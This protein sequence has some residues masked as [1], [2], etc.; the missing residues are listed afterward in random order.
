MTGLVPL[1]NR[2]VSVWMAREYRTIGHCSLC[3][4]IRTICAP[5]LQHLYTLKIH[6]F[7]LLLRDSAKPWGF[8]R[9]NNNH[10]KNSNVILDFVHCPLLFK[11]DVSESGFV[12]FMVCKVSSTVASLR[13]NGDHAMAHDISRRTLVAEARNYSQ[14]FHVEFKADKLAMTLGLLRSVFPYSFNI[15]SPMIHIHSLSYHR[16]CTISQCFST[17]ARPRPGKFF[18]Y[19]TRPQSQQIYS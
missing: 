4:Q 10:Q 8:I 17:F 14:Q 19:Q 15:I 9:L 2:N 12:S 6:R 3:E 11:H 18:F 5:E 7:L 1:T 13:T 16:L